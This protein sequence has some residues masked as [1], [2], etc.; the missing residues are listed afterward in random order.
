VNNQN[1]LNIV[2]VQPPVEDFY[3]TPHRSSTLGL[4]SLAEYWGEKG[5]SCR[6]LNFTLKKPQKKR[7]TLPDKLKYLN[8]FLQFYSKELRGT[9]FFNNYYRFGPSLDKCLEE[10]EI[11]KPDIIAVS[12]FAWSYAGTV[13]KLLE[14]LK[15]KRDLSDK[16]P[17]L[18]VGGPGVTVMPD[19]FSTCADL[20]L[21]GEGE[22][23]IDLIEQR[24]RQ[25]IFSSSGEIINPDS[26]FRFPFVYNMHQARNNK[27]N[28]IMMLSRGCPKMCSFCA[29]YLTFGKTLRKIAV[30]EVIAGMDSLIDEI[31]KGSQKGEVK[32]HV[33]FED[34]NIL[35]HKNYFL[36]ILKYIKGKCELYNIIFSFSAENGIDYLLLDIDTLTDFKDL[37]LS[38]LNL[39]MASM[40]QRQLAEEK[41]EGNLKK[42][43]LILAFSENLNIPVI[44]YFICGL[45][46]DT[47]EKIVETINYLHKLNTNIGISLYYPVPG[48]IDWQNRNIFLKEP[49]FLCCGSSSYAWNGSLSTKEM[50]TAFR[51]AR[52][53][54]FLKNSSLEKSSFKNLKSDMFKDP[55]M[56][57]TM[58]DLFF[59]SISNS[60]HEGNR[61]E[62]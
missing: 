34:D 52:T 43:E 48:L 14:M 12:C 5:H 62:K 17:L 47:P 42:L 38:Q 31:L 37:N 26:P 25:K 19:Y 49:P 51:L 57:K 13:K 18:V 32:L 2:L 39:S 15:E 41:R 6:V 22:N 29:N 33:N 7:I 30:S 21:V 1:Y 36:T 56:D 16:P 27:Y 20:I 53:S 50:I 23:A 55:T 40:D 61:R 45:K 28:V 58:V 24:F 35:F 9:A 4:Y 46:E 3:F 44:S 54:N 60:E 59:K 10:I 8:P 11:I